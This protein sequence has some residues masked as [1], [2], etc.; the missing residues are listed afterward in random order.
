MI[1]RI[2]Q[3]ME[4]SGFTSSQFADGIEVPRAI[5]SHIMSGRN[6]PSLD[7]I[8]KVA[9]KYTDVNLEWLILGKGEMLKKLAP[10]STENQV[11][12]TISKPDTPAAGTI[13]KEAVKP[14]KVQT[15]VQAEL[16]STIGAIPG[17][18]IKQIVFFYTDN[19]FSVFNPEV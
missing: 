16:P 5:L 8:L 12:E 11:D 17:K 13:N 14:A 3:L 4:Y 1:N 9:A 6:K 19:S 2:R 18:Q 10:D 15:I 7:V